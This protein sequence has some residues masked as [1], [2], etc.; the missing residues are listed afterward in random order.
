MPLSGIQKYGLSFYKHL[1]S[2]EARGIESCVYAI[3]VGSIYFLT[4]VV[5]A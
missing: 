2:S 1:I 4:H 3:V 5:A